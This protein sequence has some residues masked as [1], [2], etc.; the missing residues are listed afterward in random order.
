MATLIGY[1]MKCKAKKEMV[2]VEKVNFKMKNGKERAAA[3]GIC[4]V[5]GTKMYKILS[6]TDVL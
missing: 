3:K 6:V 5:C 1:C 4:S 2:N